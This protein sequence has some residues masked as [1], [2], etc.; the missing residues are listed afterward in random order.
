MR[1]AVSR[2]VHQEILVGFDE[3]TCGSQ[4]SQ[5]LVK[6]GDPTRHRLR[7]LQLSR[8]GQLIGHAEAEAPA[9]GSQACSANGA[10]CMWT[11]RAFS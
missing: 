6:A 8:H 7:A 11:D 1:L 2:A 9:D 5:E 10:G 4:S 3:V